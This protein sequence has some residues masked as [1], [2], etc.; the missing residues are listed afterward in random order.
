M[1]FRPAMALALAV[2]LL[3]P[4]IS[5]PADR[6]I[7]RKLDI[8]TDRTVTAFDEDGLL[9][10]RPREGGNDRITWDEVERGKVALDQPRFDKLLADLGTPLFRIRQRLKV[11]DYKAAG[12]PTE[13]L[14]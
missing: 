9:L 3:L 13:Q 1:A 11:G 8:I 2:I 14:Y 7:L 6:L 12:E 5:R 4:A 10:D